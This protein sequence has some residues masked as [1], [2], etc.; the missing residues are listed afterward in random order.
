MRLTFLEKTETPT[1]E[2]RP[3]Q[4]EEQEEEEEEVEEEEVR[5][6]RHIPFFL[7]LQLMCPG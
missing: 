1:E 5:N 3:G 4:Q 2:V 6:Y 7:L